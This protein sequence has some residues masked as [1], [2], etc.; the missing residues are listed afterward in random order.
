LEEVISTVKALD[1]DE[2]RRKVEEQEVHA[3]S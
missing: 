1:M 2:V 3:A